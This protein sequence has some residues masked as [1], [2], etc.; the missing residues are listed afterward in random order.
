MISQITELA[1]YINASRKQGYQDEAIRGAL[2]SKGWTEEIIKKAISG[3]NLQQ[4]M[5]HPP[6]QNVESEN[7]SYLSE[8]PKKIG[9]NSIYAILLA[10]VL[11]FSL[12]ILVNQA[13]DDIESYFNKDISAGLIMNGLLV[14]T[15]V[16]AS[17]LLHHSFGENKE[18]F[19]ILSKPYY[20]VS[21]WL[22]LLLL[23]RVSEFILS[24][25]TVYGVYV[26]LVLVVA[27]LTGMIFY[28]QKYLRT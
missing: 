25:E 22:L 2:L 7:P 10:I 28:I 24:K 4:N 9:I 1:D 15:L 17:F 16:V 14:L 11:F 23:F 27:V 21:A 12:L 8:K 20:L 18:K 19:L 3:A 5:P 13:T 26:V 6:D